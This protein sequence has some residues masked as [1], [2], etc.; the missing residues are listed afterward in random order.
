MVMMVILKVSG[1][2]GDFEGGDGDFEGE[3]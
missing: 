1:D 3:W 2:D